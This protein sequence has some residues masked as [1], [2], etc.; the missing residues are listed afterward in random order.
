MNSLPDYQRGRTILEI[1]PLGRV[2]CDSA[3]EGVTSQ[4]PP[5]RERG[6]GPGE[7]GDHHSNQLHGHAY[8]PVKL[9]RNFTHISRFIAP[10]VLLPPATPSGYRAFQSDD[11]L[12]EDSSLGRNFFRYTRRTKV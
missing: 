9:T 1:S 10:T 2:I 3:A 12:V 5:P 4:F 6:F 8:V 7:A 11:C